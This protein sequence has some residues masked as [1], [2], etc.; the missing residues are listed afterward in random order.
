MDSIFHVSSSLDT[1]ITASAVM[2]LESVHKDV[3]INLYDQA[4][5]IDNH[6]ENVFFQR[7]PSSKL[8]QDPFGTV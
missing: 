3:T 1:L 2:L 7:S 5:F 8:Y 4:D 6:F